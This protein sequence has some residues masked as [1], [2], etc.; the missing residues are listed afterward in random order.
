[1]TEDQSL[2]SSGDGEEYGSDT[3]EKEGRVGGEEEE[4]EEEEEDKMPP[5][6][7]KRW[8]H[9]SVELLKD[10]LERSGS[11]SGED[12]SPDGDEAGENEQMDVD[13]TSP[14]PSQS[15]LAQKYYRY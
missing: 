14:T 13:D 3:T 11:G 15:F 5:K 7:R 1:M 6:M 2:E 9:R 4:E 8:I 10:M 12:G